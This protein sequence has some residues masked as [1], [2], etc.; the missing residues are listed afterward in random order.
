[1]SDEERWGNM[2]A[3]LM[4]LTTKMAESPN[5]DIPVGIEAHMS[6]NWQKLVYDDE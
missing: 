6:M 1:M 4:G 5:E 3:T 2:R